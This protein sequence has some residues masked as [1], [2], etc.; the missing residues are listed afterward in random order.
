MENGTLDLQKDRYTRFIF[1][2][3]CVLT[4][5]IPVAQLT[6]L[7]LSMVFT[8]TC[9]GV[10][11]LVL[12]AA[13]W[14][15]LAFG[16]RYHAW[17]L[18]GQRGKVAHAMLL[19]LLWDC[20]WVAF[21]GHPIVGMT[22]TMILFTAALSACRNGTDSRKNPWQ[23]AVRGMVCVL[24]GLV[25]LLGI[26]ALLF[27]D[28][29]LVEPVYEYP[30]PYDDRVA[31]VINIDE[32]AFGG[33]TLV[34]IRRPQRRISLLLG[35]FEDKPQLVYRGEWGEFEGMTVEWGSSNTL[36]INGTAYTVNE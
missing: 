6:G 24:A 8:L 11:W 10:P 30:S 20:L 21:R 1:I 35:A 3:A 23:K 7:V 25:F 17:D 16:A 4:M 27:W 32:G 31:E 36:I 34:N 12:T 9:Y 19:L 15:M 29:T 18:R 33:S 14:C 22:G 5:L 28:F 2:S 26:P 13:C